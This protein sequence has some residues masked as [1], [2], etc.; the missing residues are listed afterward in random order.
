MRINYQYAV[1][2]DYDGGITANPTRIF[3]NRAVDAVN[4]R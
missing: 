4:Y 1:I 3:R 2:K